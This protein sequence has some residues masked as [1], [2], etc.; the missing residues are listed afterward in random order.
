M[1]SCGLFVHVLILAC[2]P[3]IPENSEENNIILSRF[4]PFYML[5]SFSFCRHWKDIQRSCLLN[6]YYSYK[7]YLWLLPKKI[8]LKQTQKQTKPNQ[9]KVKK[10]K[11]DLGKMCQGNVSISLMCFFLSF[12]VECHPTVHISVNKSIDSTIDFSCGSLPARS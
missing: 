4:I 1:L 5:I 6:L 10:K 8:F 11:K 9:N 12:F 3:S 2:I 7:Y